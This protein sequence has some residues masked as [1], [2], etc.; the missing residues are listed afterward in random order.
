MKKRSPD[1]TPWMDAADYGRSLRPGLG[2]NLLVH[3]VARAVTFATEALGASATYADADFAVLRLAGSEWMLHAD[4]AYQHFGDQVAGHH[5]NQSADYGQ[6]QRF[7]KKL[8]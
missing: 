4:H 6:C 1:Q 3:D 7:E 8:Q 5:A 2:I